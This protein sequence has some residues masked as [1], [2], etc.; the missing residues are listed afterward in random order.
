MVISAELATLNMRQ[1]GGCQAV[2]FVV[3]IDNGD[4]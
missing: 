4:Y 2:E 3:E 1:D